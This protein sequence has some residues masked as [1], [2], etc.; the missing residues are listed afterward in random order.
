MGSKYDNNICWNLKKMQKF[1]KFCRNF[2]M[3][4][5]G[6]NGLFLAFFSIFRQKFLAGGAFSG[7]NFYLPAITSHFL[8]KFQKKN[9]IIIIW[10]NRQTKN[11]VQIWPIFWKW[12]QEQKF[13]QRGVEISATPKIF[14][15]TK[16]DVRKNVYNNKCCFPDPVVVLFVCFQFLLL[17]F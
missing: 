12:P 9:S 17:I 3:V 6:E 11:L 5:G 10:E 8:P 15:V 16:Y 14:G 4:P 1:L 2:C 7:R 13:L